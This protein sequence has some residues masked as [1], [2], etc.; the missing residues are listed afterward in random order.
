MFIKF[1]FTS[2]DFAACNKVPLQQKDNCAQH[3][4]C[5]WGVFRVFSSIYKIIV[6]RG[7]L[8]LKYQD[9]IMAVLEML[10]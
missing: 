2:S 8:S 4:L 7:K 9:F 1:A 3:E 10:E 5:V 6:I